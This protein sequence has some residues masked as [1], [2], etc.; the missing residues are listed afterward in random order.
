MIL[1][2]HGLQALQKFQNHLHAGEVNAQVI[3]QLPNALDPLDV[4]ARE[5]A[6]VA[7]RTIR[8]DNPNRS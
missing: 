2:L 8:L 3:H 4:A 1:A 6:L 7:L 5:Y